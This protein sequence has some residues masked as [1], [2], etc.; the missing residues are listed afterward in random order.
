VNW[1]KKDVISSKE[2]ML[3]VGDATTLGKVFEKLDEI[4]I[5][6][7]YIARVSHSKLEEFKK[8][9][10]IMA[11]KA[12]KEKADYL[13]TAIGEQTGKA[14]I[15]QE[16]AHSLRIDNE[17]LNSRDKDGMKYLHFNLDKDEYEN[18]LQ[19]QK[20]KLQSALYVKF[21]IK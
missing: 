19:F 1:T 18:V 13:L 4:K 8:Q 9:V 7:A 14:L 6:D 21:E 15:V 16:Q 10:R 5:H 12:A 2:Y 3:K 11:I 20:I 17:N